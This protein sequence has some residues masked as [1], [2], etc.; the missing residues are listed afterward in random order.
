MGKQTEEQISLS[1]LEKSYADSKE[2]LE[3]LLGDTL[4]KAGG[5][6]PKVRRAAGSPDTSPG[7][8]PD[9]SEDIDTDDIERD[10]EDYDGEESEEDTLFKKSIEDQM[11]EDEDAE[12]AMDVEPFLRSLVQNLDKRFEQLGKS[13]NVMQKSMSSLT[14]LSKAQSRALLAFQDL[15][16]SVSDTVEAIAGTPVTSPSVLRKSGTSR[17]ADKT[18]LENLQ[19]G[20]IMERALLA[21]S[22]GLLHTREVSMIE[23]RLNKGL[24]LEPSWINALQEVSA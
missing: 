16:K 6:K 11:S 18:G 10:D 4:S 24:D 14:T 15:Q 9:G 2:E 22:K 19:S 7:K 5:K 20:E 23:G 1:D 3:G 13:L 12:A 17:F 8:T 21:K